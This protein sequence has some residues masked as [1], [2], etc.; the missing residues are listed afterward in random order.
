MNDV[1]LALSQLSRIRS[2]LVASTQFRGIAPGFNVLMGVLVLLVASVQSLQPVASL[3]D[4]RGFVLVWA[5]VIGIFS[6]VAI[7]EAV[8]RARRLHGSMAPAMLDS[9]LQKVLPFAMTGL[10]VTGVILSFAPESAW[11][12]PG[13]WLMLIGLQGFSFLSSMPRG[14]VWAAMWYFLCGAIVLIAAGASRT[15]SPWMMGIPF[16]VGC[17][18][19]ALIVG[20][21]VGENGVCKEE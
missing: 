9:M 11:L 12:L 14:M 8:F 7:V 18:S 10:V 13:F 4:G 17:F 6:V 20:R 21:V 2:Q 15:L 1:N 3:Q 16:A 5:A 19:V